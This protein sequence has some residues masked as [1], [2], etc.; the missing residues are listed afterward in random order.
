M[1]TTLYLDIKNDFFCV[2][3]A[4]VTVTM[5]KVTCVSTPCCVMSCHG[6]KF[7]GYVMLCDIPP[8]ASRYT[9]AYFSKNVGDCG[10]LENY[11]DWFW[12]V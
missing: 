9:A 7:G 4:Y 12:T 6:A 1:S 10:C 5:Y 3:Y 2:C 8:K 11:V